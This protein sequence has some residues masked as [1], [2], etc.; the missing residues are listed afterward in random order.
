VSRSTAA[1]P[2]ATTGWSSTIATR[3]GARP[4]VERQVRPAARPATHV[5]DRADRLRPLLHVEQTKVAGR[6]RGLGGV[7]VDARSC[8]VDRQ[9]GATGR[10]RVAHEDRRF[11]V[12]HSVRQGLL[13]DPEES[14]LDVGRRARPVGPLQANLTTGEPFDPQHEPVERGPDA[15]I[16]EDR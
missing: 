4:P 13:G 9:R 11:A 7:G 10:R 14:E 15:E 12:L 16:V 2:S 5:E 6:V 1:V 8:V 3:I